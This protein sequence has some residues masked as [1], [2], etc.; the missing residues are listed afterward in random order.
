MHMLHYMNINWIYIYHLMEKY[1]SNPVCKLTLIHP[2]DFIK[3]IP[4]LIKMI[5]KEYKKKL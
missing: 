3:K 1:V 2:D 4:S 5:V